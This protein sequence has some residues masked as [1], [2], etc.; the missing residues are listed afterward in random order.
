MDWVKIELDCEMPND[1]E[2]L[3]CIHN[4]KWER[5]VYMGCD[6]WSGGNSLYPTR[7]DPTHWTRVEPPN[8]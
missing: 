6:Y 3:L 7:L 4:G 2:V 8:N 1:G 5:V